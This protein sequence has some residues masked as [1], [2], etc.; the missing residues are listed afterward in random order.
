MT[1]I[2][3]KDNIQ[4]GSIL[5]SNPIRLIPLSL[6]IRPKAVFEQATV[7]LNRMFAPLFD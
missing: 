2:L 3:I 6:D 5:L 1:N 4:D 7:K